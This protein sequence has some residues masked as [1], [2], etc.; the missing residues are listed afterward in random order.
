M[1]G[2]ITTP[3]AAREMLPDD[4]TAAS[5]LF[6]ADA[7]AVGE[8]LR[9]L[10]FPKHNTDA[11]AL[12]AYAFGCYSTFEYREDAVRLEGEERLELIGLDFGPWDFEDDGDRREYESELAHIERNATT[13]RFFEGGVQIDCYWY[14]DG[15]GILLYRV[16]RGAS[17][18]IV[19]N[20][21]CKK[22]YRWVERGRR[23]GTG[24]VVVPAPLPVVES[25]ADS[26]EALIVGVG[27]TGGGAQPTAALQ[28]ARTEASEALEAYRAASRNGLKR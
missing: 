15:D 24:D 1:S 26:V 20:G 25:L 27:A 8:I 5:I 6:N 12:D 23:I 14:W 22:N 16:R 19:S 2:V 28:M 13:I 7:N 10:T 18:R 17:E 4:L 21:D 9:A 11:E 3:A